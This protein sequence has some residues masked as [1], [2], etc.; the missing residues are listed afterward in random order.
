M[1]LQ[2]LWHNE[3]THDGGVQNSSTQRLYLGYWKPTVELSPVVPKR[4][5]CMQVV[6][7]CSAQAHLIPFATQTMS[8]LNAAMKTL[9]PW[10]EVYAWSRSLVTSSMLGLCDKFMLKFS[11]DCWRKDLGA[12]ATWWVELVMSE[13]SRVSAVQYNLYTRGSL[14][15]RVYSEERELFPSLHP[16]SRGV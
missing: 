3:A 2:L 14:A 11:Q 5:F 13:P 15:P 16:P 8:C 1:H 9:Q 4:T 7:L 10:L 12:D 6:T